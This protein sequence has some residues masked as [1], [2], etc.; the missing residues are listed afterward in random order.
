MTFLFKIQLITAQGGG[1]ARAYPSG[2]VSV[3]IGPSYPSGN[4]PAKSYNSTGTST[5][6]GTGNTPAET[7]PGD[8]EY[9][10]VK[11]QPAPATDYSIGSNN[12]TTTSNCTTTPAPAGSCFI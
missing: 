5:G 11:Q 6:I 2:G 1:G 8:P 10:G 3:P 7:Y 4:I 9:T 12:C